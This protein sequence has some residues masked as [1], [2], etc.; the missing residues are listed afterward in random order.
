MQASGRAA[1]DT[2]IGG[3]DNSDKRQLATAA[4]M[5]GD[6]SCEGRQRQA[7]AAA[8]TSTATAGDSSY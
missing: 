8:A 7:K 5:A 3:V 1:D 2:T 6:G 4:A